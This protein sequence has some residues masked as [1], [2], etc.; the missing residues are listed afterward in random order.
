MRDDEKVIKALQPHR[1]LTAFEIDGFQGRELPLRM[2][3]MR[4]LSQV[5]IVRCHSCTRLP[6]I[7][8][9][10]LL[11][12]LDLHTLQ[13]MSPPA[14]AFVT[15]WRGKKALGEGFARDWVP[16]AKCSSPSDGE[17]SLANGEGFIYPS[18]ISE[19]LEREHSLA[20]WRGH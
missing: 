9:L 6:P 11:K 1:N 10:P 18:P 8:D 14:R 5:H 4:N 16:S 12:V 7:R 3:K 15:D 13:K 17:G 2:K 19:G 20:N